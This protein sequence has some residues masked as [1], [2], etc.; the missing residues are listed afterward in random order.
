M[1]PMTT[2]TV[3]IPEDLDK[4][5]REY[6]R[7]QHVSVE[8]AVQ[9]MLRDLLTAQKFEDLCRRTEKYARAAGVTSED[10]LLQDGP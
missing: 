2:L 8:E 10:E 6:C 3:N 1:D 4:G 7:Q 5:L 9:E